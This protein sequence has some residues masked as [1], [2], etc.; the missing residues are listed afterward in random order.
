M[1]RIS[2]YLILLAGIC[3]AAD[4]RPQN[5]VSLDRYMGRWYEQAR[6]ENWFEQGMEGVYTDYTAR[7][8]GSIRVLNC[9]HNANGE[10]EQATGRAFPMSHGI[11]EV[12]FVWP[13][14]WFGAPYHILYVDKDYQAAL[15]S[16]DDDDYLWLLTRERK[17][18]QSTINKLKQEAER[19]GFDTTKLRFTKQ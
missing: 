3:T 2:T 12:S 7:P 10:P 15:V 9:G 4:T 17:P 13:Y 8:D 6:Y 19:R 5:N 18:K 16:G 11:L 1:K 14:W